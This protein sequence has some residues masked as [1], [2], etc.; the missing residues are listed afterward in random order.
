MKF[1]IADFYEN[2]ARNYRFVEHWTKYRTFY[3]KTNVRVIIAG[4]IRKLAVKAS[5]WNVIF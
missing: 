4:D 1:D 2:L 5:L 3:R